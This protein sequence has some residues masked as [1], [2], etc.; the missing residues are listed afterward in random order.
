MIN[1]ENTSLEVKQE[2][3]IIDG[4]E[5]GAH[6][7]HDE[8]LEKIKECLSTEEMESFMESW[9]IKIK[10]LNHIWENIMNVLKQWK[11]TTVEWD[12]TTIEVSMQDHL[13]WLLYDRRT[14]FNHSEITY[15]IFK[16]ELEKLKNE[17][18]E[19]GK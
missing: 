15:I 10:Y 13:I 4:I 2:R 14:E 8:F 7:L 1:I 3:H 12:T 5:W 18:L 6:E 9:M 11:Q 19:S 17:I 16:E